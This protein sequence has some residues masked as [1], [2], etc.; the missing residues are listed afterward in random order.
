MENTG[1]SGSMEPDLSPSSDDKINIK[2]ILVVIVAFVIVAASLTLHLH[3]CSWAEYL[4]QNLDEEEAE[5]AQVVHELQ[6]PNAAGVANGGNHQ[7]LAAAGVTT[8]E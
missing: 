6:V 7:P 1:M 3:S 8:S 5:T 2:V 4:E